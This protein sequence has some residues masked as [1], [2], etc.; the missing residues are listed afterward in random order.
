MTH[1]NSLFRRPSQM[2]PNNSFKPTAGVGQLIRQPS[3]AG[4]GLIQ[5]LGTGGEMSVL[6]QWT[7]AMLAV[8]GAFFVAGISGSIA[9]DA[10]GFWHLPGAGFLAALAAV[11]TTYFAAPSQK[12]LFSGGVFVV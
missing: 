12:I 7:L 11:V 3:R 10:L 6:K 4:G 8:L 5:V 9:T 2:A 1:K